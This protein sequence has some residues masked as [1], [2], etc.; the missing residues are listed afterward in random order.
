MSEIQA[1]VSTHLGGFKLDLQFQIP[2]QGVTALF[3]RSGSGK[4]TVLRWL[5]GLLPPSQKGFLKVNDEIWE[6]SS[7]G[8]FLPAHERSVGYVFQ[9]NN[10]FPHLSVRKNLLYATSKIPQTSQ[11]APSNKIEFD[12][13][14]ENLGLTGLLEKQPH[15]L[16]GGERQRVAIARSLLMKPKILL[17]D[18][19]LSAL[20]AKSKSEIFPFLE[21]IKTEAQVPI[22]FVSHSIDEVKYF[23]DHVLHIE[24]G[25]MLKTQ[26]TILTESDFK[27]PFRQEQ[28]KHPLAV[29]F[30]GRS[31]SGK[32]TLVEALIPL[33]KNKG[34]KLGAIKHDAHQ[35]E[36]DHKGKDSFRF[37]HAGAD[38]VVISSSDKLAL[39]SKTKAP[40]SVESILDQYFSDFDLVLTEGY[41][42]SSIPKIFVTR[43]PL[44]QDS[45]AG[46]SG[47]VLAIATDQLVNVDDIQ[48]LDLNN[49]EAI[50]KFVDEWVALNRNKN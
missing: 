11:K 35:F 36:I 19:P 17:L 50:A 20:D 12:K 27:V 32:T 34:Y 37:A 48:Y 13:M 40:Q 45:M 49:P 7:Q 1:K 42:A 23:C 22:L 24:N 29:S 31:G 47:K 10:L 16:S 6:D 8:L 9:E 43:E 21:I 26:N 25:P 14:V 2:G 18:E 5:A 30:V 44:G 38:S 39:V 15:Q 41:K 28:R 33:L 3:G 4:T 46:V